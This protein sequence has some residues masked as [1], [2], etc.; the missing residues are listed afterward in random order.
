MITFKHSWES[1]EWTLKSTFCPR[2]RSFCDEKIKEAV[3]GYQWQ[4]VKI[5]EKPVKRETFT[6]EQWKC[7]LQ[8]VLMRFF[9]KI[10]FW[11]RF[12][13]FAA[14]RWFKIFQGSSGFC[15]LQFLRQC[16]PQP[17]TA[18][19]ARV[20][21]RW[22]RKP[23]S[24]RKALRYSSN[25]NGVSFSLSINDLSLSLLVAGDSTLSFDY[26]STGRRLETFLGFTPFL[27]RTKIV[28]TAT[29]LP[30]PAI[31]WLE[32]FSVDAWSWYC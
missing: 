2:V 6:R 3:R 12:H 4:R 10:G 29:L 19:T 28:K 13:W 23:F 5:N 15:H 31:G 30:K 21:I 8:I 18:A 14:R 7:F 9:L 32:H 1:A 27:A 20:R 16:S 25:D 17:R 11:N 26:S 22:P 24:F